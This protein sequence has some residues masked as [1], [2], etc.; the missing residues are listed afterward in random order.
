MLLGIPGNEDADSLASL[1][2]VLRDILGDTL[3]DVG[4]RHL[5]NLEAN[6][7]HI[8][9]GLGTRRQL[10]GLAQV[11]PLRVHLVTEYSGKN[12]RRQREWY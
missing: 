8:Q 4:R 2:S 3:N 9:I 6:K 7:E 12:I 5:P 1:A 11:R 10:D